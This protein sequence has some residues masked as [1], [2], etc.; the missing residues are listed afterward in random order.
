MTRRLASYLL[1]LYSAA[2]HLAGAAPAHA[3]TPAK[4]VEIR[5][6]PGE[7]WWGGLSVDGPRMPY[8]EARPLH[9]ERAALRI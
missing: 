2:A 9:M 4:R 3:G 5:L 7:Y 8:G 1:L 6:E